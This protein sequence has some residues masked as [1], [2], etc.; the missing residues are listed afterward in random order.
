VW[1][2]TCLLTASWLFPAWLTL[3]TRRRYSESPVDF[4]RAKCRYVPEDRIL[5]VSFRTFNVSYEILRRRTTSFPSTNSI[6]LSPW[7]AASRSAT[8]EFSNI[9]WNPKGH[10]RVNR[11]HPLDPILSQINLVH[12]TQSYLRS[13][14]ILSSHLRI[15]F[16]S[17]LSIALP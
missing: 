1:N 12:T 8:E 11:N 16:P 10:Y 7:E 4:K 6:E 9:L 13:T 14:L 3:Q 5:R 17:G 15:D 2:I